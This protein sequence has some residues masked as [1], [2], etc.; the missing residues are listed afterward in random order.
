MGTVPRGTAAYFG[1]WRD[2]QASAR[3]S[4]EPSSVLIAFVM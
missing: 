2:S 3:L 4:A 1:M